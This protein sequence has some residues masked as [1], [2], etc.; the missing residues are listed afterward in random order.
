MRGYNLIAVYSEKCDKLLMCRRRKNPYIGLSNLIGGKIEAGESGIDAAYRELKEESGITGEAI[1]LTHV[2]DL[3]YHLS[4]CYVEVYA[5]RLNKAISVTG[6]ENELYWSDTDCDFF[7]E[8][9][10]AGEGNLGHIIEQ[11]ELHRDK[12]LV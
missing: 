9:K 10:Y 12:A 5:G 7:D 6:D 3:V 4:D 11:I 1:S 8:T 2:M